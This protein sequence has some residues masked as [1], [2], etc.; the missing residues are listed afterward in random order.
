MMWDEHEQELPWEQ[1]LVT[2]YLHA[3]GPDPVPVPDIDAALAELATAPDHEISEPWA[4]W[5]LSAPERRAFQA[6]RRRVQRRLSHTCSCCGG[7]F[8]GK[9]LSDNGPH[10]IRPASG[11]CP[12][13]A[14]AGRRRCVG[15]GEVFTVDDGRRRTCEDCRRR[16]AEAHGVSDA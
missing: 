2:D 8:S 4:G 11:V 6:T 13:C 12:G 15:C 5:L 9:I 10:E 7:S 3:G 16:R 14:S 1:R